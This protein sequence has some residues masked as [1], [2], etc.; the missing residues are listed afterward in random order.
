M[1]KRGPDNIQEFVVEKVVAHNKYKD[2]EVN[3]LRRTLTK[4]QKTTT[5][6]CPSCELRPLEHIFYVDI[7]HCTRLGCDEERESCHKCQ[8]KCCESCLYSCMGEDFRCN[9]Q[10]CI[11]CCDGLFCFGCHLGVGKMFPC[12][13][14]CEVLQPYTF[15]D[16]KTA[17]YACAYCREYWR[18]EEKDD[19]NV[20]SNV[21]TLTDVKN[22]CKKVDE[23]KAIIHALQQ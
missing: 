18:D 8:R 10:T 13:K 16:G 11:L 7:V 23:K 1:K 3:R 19:P 4:L 2:F 14:H 5:S 17:P 12:D 6:E 9:S 21:D 20:Y 22:Y 15:N